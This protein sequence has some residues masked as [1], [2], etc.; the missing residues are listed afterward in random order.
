MNKAIPILIAAVL[1]FITVTAYTYSGLECAPEGTVSISQSGGT[2]LDGTLKQLEEYPAGLFYIEI[3]DFKGESNEWKRLAPY[4]ARVA[5]LL[6]E[7]SPTFSAALVFPQGAPRICFFGAAYFKLAPENYAV[8]GGMKTLSALHLIN[9]NMKDTNAVPLKGLTNLR[10]LVVGKNLLLTGKGIHEFAGCKNLDTLRMWETRVSDSS[11]PVLTNF[12]GL[13]ELS[14]GKNLYT[15][16]LQ[17]VGLLTNLRHLD[18]GNFQY[19]PGGAYAHLTN[20]R[21]LEDLNL[22]FS[23]LDE[24][25]A[26]YLYPLR[27][28]RLLALYKVSWGE[29]AVI[30]LKKNLPGCAVEYTPYNY[31]R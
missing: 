27:N 23:R 5:G 25:A 30:K 3:R 31:Y 17:Y 29:P 2:T 21:L 28:L 24:S 9:V 6:V 10:R 26:E 19:M 11:M 15:N 7:R 13:R 20:L 4:S 12:P 14:I 1:A 16:G 18:I 8:I 22:S